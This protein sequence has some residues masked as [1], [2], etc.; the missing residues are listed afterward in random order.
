MNTGRILALVGTVALSGLF[1]SVAMGTGSPFVGGH[2]N[3][4]SGGNLRTF[5]FTV[6][7]KADGTVTGNVEVKNRSLDVRAHIEVDCLQLVGATR[8]IVGGTI[9]QSSNPGLIGI[10]RMS[11]FGV[12]DNGEGDAAP[13]DRITTIP[14]YAPP[15]SCHEFTFVGD[16]LREIANPSIVVRTLTPITGGDIQVQ[17]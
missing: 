17:P 16:T 2:G 1:V 8:A 9:T 7:E 12:E 13:P 11:V 14:D 10:G 4:V 5:S 3:L 6:V 15:K